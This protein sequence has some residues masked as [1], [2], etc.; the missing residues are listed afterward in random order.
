MAEGVG[1]TVL[2]AFGLLGLH[3]VEADVQPGNEP[4]PAVPRGRAVDP[5]GDRPDRPGRAKTRA[6]S[7]IALR[8]NR[9]RTRV[10]SAAG[11]P[12]MAK[13]AVL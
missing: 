2:Y 9:F 8:T 4:S 3:R 12:R 11:E 7:L 5:F 13:E 10:G 6:S 1:L